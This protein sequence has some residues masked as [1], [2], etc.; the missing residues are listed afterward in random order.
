M[1][2]VITVVASSFDLGSHLLSHVRSYLGDPKVDYSIHPDRMPRG[3]FA[4]VWQFE[5]ADAP[6]EWSGG[7]VVRLY[8]SA[9]D[10]VDLQVEAAVQNGLVAEGFPAPKVLLCEDSP[11]VLGRR[12]IIMERLPGRPRLRGVRWD[13]FLRDLPGLVRSWPFELAHVAARLH[14]C[15]TDAVK[16]E[17]AQRGVSLSVIGWDRHLRMLKCRVMT[18][19]S[20]SGWAQGLSWLHSH[21]PPEP[22]VP[23]MVHGDLWAANFLYEGSILTGLVDWDRATLAE[24]ALDIGFAKAGWALMPAPTRVPPPIY[25]G[26]RRLGRSVADRIEREY[27]AL[28]PIDPDRVRYYEA[29]RCALELSGVVDGGSRQRPAGSSQGWENGAN[30]LAAHFEEITGTRLE[31]KPP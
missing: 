16:T 30:A 28:V 4:E 26:L 19:R 31:T 10:S 29:L 15:P 21:L 14:K 17:A 2:T 1:T 6:P 27:G 23:V 24:P 22:S 8:P 13:R 25:Q 3:M 18:I 11:E 9:A 12:F 5:L 7:L 20:M